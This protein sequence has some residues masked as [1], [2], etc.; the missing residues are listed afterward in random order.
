[1]Q[2]NTSSLEVEFGAV[3]GRLEDI[4]LGDGLELLQ[5]NCMGKNYKDLKSQERI[6]SPM[7]LVLRIMCL[8]E[9]Y[10]KTAFGA[11]SLS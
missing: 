5:R 6:S 8:V 9:R 10:R 3:F 1:M 7:R 4:I 11:N 2:S